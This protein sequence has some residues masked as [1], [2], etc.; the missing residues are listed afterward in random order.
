MWRALSHGGLGRRL[1]VTRHRDLSTAAQSPRIV[2][3]RAWEAHLRQHPRP[4]KAARKPDEEKPWPRSFQI[5]GYAMAAF[6]IPYSIAWL[7]ASSGPVRAILSSVIPNL[8]DHLR[9]HFG[10]E[11]H[12][13]NCLLSYYE[14]QQGEEPKYQLDDEPTFRERLQY[15]QVEA[16]KRSQVK[17]RVRVDG[18][19]DSFVETV[20]PGSIPARSEAILKAIGKEGTAVAL[21]FGNFISDSPEE[22]EEENDPPTSTQ[23]DFP[24]ERQTCMYSLWYYLSP[25]QHP[26][27]QESSPRISSQDIEVSRLEHE[28]QQLQDDLNNVNC[29]RDIDDMTLELKEK[30]SALRNLRWKRRLGI[31]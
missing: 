21:D 10:H 1:I 27:Q 20:L 7:A 29:I 19:A 28:I 2:S 26:Q 12:D 14:R 11:E 24:L 16:L 22:E 6:F 30:K 17:V 5:A 23:D 3:R 9:H 15:E 31:S 8:D 25:M 18:D 13:P 4:S